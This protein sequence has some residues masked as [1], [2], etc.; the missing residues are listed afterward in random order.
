MG[1]FGFGRKTGID[2]EGEENGIL[3]SRQWKQEHSRQPWYPGETIIAGIGQG[4]WAVTPLQLAHALSILAG[5]GIPRAPRLVMATQATVDAPRVPLPNPPTG[6]SLV[7]D[8]AH[9]DVIRQGMEAVVA[10]GTGAKQFIGFPLLVAGKSGTAERFSRTTSAYD[11]NKNSAYLASR[12]RAWFEAFAPADDPKISVVAMLEAGAWGAEASGPIVR[13][14][15][16]A[17]LA[18]EG[19]AVAGPKPPAATPPP[20][21]PQVPEDLPVQA[22]GGATP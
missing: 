12:H 2:L 6:P 5:H 3:P 22:D 8:P 1:R 18:A 14:I 10:S 7:K 4:Y 15:M 9:L 20:G 21:Q 16:E 19:G 11:T 13:T 17:W